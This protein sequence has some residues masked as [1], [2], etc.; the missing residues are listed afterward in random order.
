[1]QCEAGAQWARIAN[2]KQGVRRTA[3]VKHAHR[4][5]QCKCEDNIKR[6]NDSTVRGAHAVG[7]IASEER[8]NDIQCMRKVRGFQKEYAI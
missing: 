2:A 6:E 4:R 7:R 1:M 3:G 8:R 5:E